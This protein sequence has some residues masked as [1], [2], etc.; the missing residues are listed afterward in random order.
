[1]NVEVI[2]FYPISENERKGT[3]TGTIRI[4]L[5][6]SGIHIL[7]VIAE[8]KK[9]SCSFKI[10]YKKGFC[11]K[12][13]ADTNFPVLSFED[14]ERQRLFMEAVKEKGT[15]FIEAWL[16][17]SDSREKQPLNELKAREQVEVKETYEKPIEAKGTVYS[18]K[19]I[20]RVKK[21]E[22]RDPPPLKKRAMAGAK[23]KR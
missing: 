4:R 17:K 2:E 1:M 8:K 11:H 9:N 3:L 12:T 13:G 16:L 18:Q 20:P 15:E 22:Y 21:K 14:K 5:P 19:L 6:D 7:G 10:P 23:V